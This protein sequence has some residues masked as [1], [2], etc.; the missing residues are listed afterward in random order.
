MIVFVAPWSTVI[1]KQQIIV[2]LH[3]TLAYPSP[4]K[5]ACYIMITVD[6]GSTSIIYN[7]TNQAPNSIIRVYYR[8]QRSCGQG[9]VFTRVC[10][11]VNR[12]VSASV[13]AGI[14]PSADPLGSR[15]PGADTPWE[16]TPTPRSRHL[17]Q[18]RQPPP[19]SR[20]QHT[21]NEWPVSILLECILVIHENFN[22]FYYPSVSGR[23]SLGINLRNWLVSISS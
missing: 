10:D 12:G 15:P 23:H 18:S 9:Y 16:Q 20:L 3:R 8:P 6:R 2:Y 14:P 1:V 5:S 19:P 22:Q 21:V 4:W 17:P 11:S 13:H 7:S